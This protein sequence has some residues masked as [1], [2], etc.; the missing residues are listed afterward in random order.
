MYVS[1]AKLITMAKLANKIISYLITAEIGIIIKDMLNQYLS[2]II[3][4]ELKKI[5]P[6][7]YFIIDIKEATKLLNFSVNQKL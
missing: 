5:T 1:K 6:F 4:N 3:L 2:K 7:K